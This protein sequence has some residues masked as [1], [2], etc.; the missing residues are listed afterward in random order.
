MLSKYIFRFLSDSS[1]YDASRSYRRLKGNTVTYE[2]EAQKMEVEDLKDK[3]FKAFM[4][5]EQS[6][7]KE[8]I[9]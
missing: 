8:L 7:E 3:D 2:M 9:P 4:R 1:F 6:D 5:G